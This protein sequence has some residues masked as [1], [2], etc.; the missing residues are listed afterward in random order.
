MTLNIIKKDEEAIEQQKSFIESLANKINQFQHLE[1][2]AEKMT[3]YSQY[4]L[5]VIGKLEST[6]A[7]IL[8]VL[9]DAQGGHVNP[10]LITP[11]QIKRQLT[12]ID[13]NI[14]Q[15]FLV[16]GSDSHDFS[17]LYKTMRIKAYYVNQR[18]LFKLQVLLLQNVKY[19]LF[20]LISVPTFQNDKYVWIEPATKYMLASINRHS[21]ASLD[22]KEL[23]SCIDYSED[24]LICNGVNK[25]YNAL[26]TKYVGEWKL[27]NNHYDL[28]GSCGLKFTPISDVWIKLRQPNQ[29]IYVINKDYPINIICGDRVFHKVLKGEGILTL[30]EKCTLKHSTM[31][32]SSQTELE[33]QMVGSFIPAI[34]VSHTITKLQDMNVLSL[35]ESSFKRSNTTSIEEILHNI[36]QQQSLPNSLN[37]HYIHHYF[38]TYLLLIIIIVFVGFKLYKFKNR[39]MKKKPVIAEAL[40]SIRAFSMPNL[41]RENVV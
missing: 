22:E 16:P 18:M 28:D 26:S 40:E 31:E 30:K 34:N 37:G 33:Q 25:L 21:F 35:K 20:N 38:I 9:L 2:A 29:W 1:T 36:R 39:N 13:D 7:T 6:Q 3:I 8:D 11:T 32:I 12:L 19:Q 14:D 41:T 17:K 23:S 5:F 15:T 27:L 10:N 24:T 4:L